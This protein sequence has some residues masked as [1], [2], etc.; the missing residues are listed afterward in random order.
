MTTALENRGDPTIVQ[1]VVPF[2]IITPESVWARSDR[3]CSE[4]GHSFPLGVSLT[5][6]LGLVTTACNLTPHDPADHLRCL[7]NLTEWSVYI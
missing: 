6:E 3:S 7:L 1:R 5:T 2:E 4:P